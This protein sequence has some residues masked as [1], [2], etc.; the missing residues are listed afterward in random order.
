MGL[1]ITAIGL[2]FYT[3]M[4]ITNVAVMDV[5]GSKIQASTFGLSSLMTQIVVFPTPMVAG[6]FI[7]GYGI[8]SA[9]L[10]AAAF[11]LLAA[12]IVAPLRLSPGSSH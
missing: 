2:F 8:F 11:A 6:F 5:A 4:S 7:E 3:L 10:M 12:L 1:V 9:F